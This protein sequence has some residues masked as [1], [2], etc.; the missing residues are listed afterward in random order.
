MISLSDET[1][2]LLDR[3]LAAAVT[4]GKVLAVSF[5]VTTAEEEIYI[6][7][8][9]TKATHKSTGDV[10][11]N[12]MYWMCSMAKIVPCIA[13]LQ[14][15]ESGLFSYDTPVEELLPELR[16]PVVITPDTDGTTYRPAENK[17]LMKHLLNHSSGLSYAI[18]FYEGA[19]RVES[20]PWPY[21]AAAFEGYGW[22]GIYGFLD[23]DTGIAAM[24][25]TQVLPTRDTEVVALFER[26]EETI[27]KAVG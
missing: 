9:G 21:Q 7:H 10:D 27:Y 5:A 22:A 26:L 23:P 20:L 13:L 8:A 19:H 25:A 14:M 4:D 17:I 15:I 12:S 1:K 18:P 11:N 6:G 24:Y 2:S 3:I 16:D